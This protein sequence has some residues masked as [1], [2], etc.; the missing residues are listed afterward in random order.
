MAT[1]SAYHILFKILFQWYAVRFVQSSQRQYNARTHS[2]ALCLPLQDI[3]R[4]DLPGTE[5]IFVL[6]FQPQSIFWTD[7]SQIHHLVG[8]P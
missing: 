8:L 7:Q 4:A 2:L 3:L 5:R 1:L 6:G